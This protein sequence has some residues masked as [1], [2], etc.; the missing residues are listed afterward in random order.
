MPK[1]KKRERKKKS[2]TILAQVAVGNPRR[3][4][5]NGPIH[6]TVRFNS[7]RWLVSQSTPMFGHSSDEVALASSVGEQLFVRG[8]TREEHEAL[9]AAVRR[10]AAALMWSRGTAVEVMTTQHDFG[11][12]I[13]EHSVKQTCD[14]APPAGEQDAGDDAETICQ[15]IVNAPDEPLLPL[16]EEIQEVIKLPP[17]EHI[18]ERNAEHIVQVPVPQTLEEVAE[19]VQAVKNAPQERISEKSGEQMTGPSESDGFEDCEARGCTGAQEFMSCT[20]C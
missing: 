16:Q 3:L 13:P 19:V 10:L 14:I 2:V 7:A 12:R 8:P 6:I 18:L 15:Q 9:V 4:E 20:C 17:T 11:E 1:K 5:P